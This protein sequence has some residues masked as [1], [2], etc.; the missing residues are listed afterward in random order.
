MALYQ[1][2]PDRKLRAKA[3]AKEYGIGGHSHD[4]L[5]GSRGFV[6]HDW[7][8]LEFDHYPDHQKIT[9]KWAQVEKYIDLMIQSDRYLTDKEKEQRTARQEAECQLPMLDGT[10]AAEYTALKKQYPNTLVGFELNGNYLFYDKDAVAVER[11]L[12][13]NLLSQENVLGKV[14]VTGFPSEQW[15]AESKK[16]WAAGNNVYLAGLNENGS[17][18]QTKYLR[19]ADYLPIGSIIKLDGRDFRVEHVNFT[20]K[21]VSL[22]D[23]E[24]TKNRLPIFRNEHLPHIRELYEEQQDAAIELVPEKE[25]SYKVGDEV[26]VD[27]PTRTIEGT[28]GYIGDTDV[29]I[30][31][32]AHGQSWDNEVINKR[33]F[34]D[35]LR[36]V[37]AQL[38]D[39]ELDELPISAVMDGKV[40]TFPDATAL[41]EAL[42]A[43]P[44]PEPAGNFRITDDHLGEGGAKQKY[45]RN[46]EAIRTLFKLEQEHR[47]ATAEEQQVLSQYVGWGGLSDAFDPSKDNWAKE[48][49]ELKNLLSEDEYT[50]ARSSTLNAH[51]TS[52]VVIRSIYEAVEKMGFKS[53]NI[54][55]PSMGVGNFFGMLPD[56]MADS[57]LYGVELDSI[58]GRIAKKLYPQ[59]DITVA[60]FETTDRRD[61][62]DLAIGNVP[63]G[64]YK[65]NDKAYNKLGFNIHNYFFA[66]AIDQVRPGGVIAFVTSRYT[67]DSKD[68]TARKHMAE[69]A[70]LLG[71]IRLPNN[72]FKANAGTEV[73]SDIIFLQKRDRP[74]DHEPDWV[75]LGKTEDGFAINQYF[76]DHPEMVLGELTTESTP[77]GHDLTV[78]PIEGAVLADQLAEA[79][80]HIEGQYVEV[81][82]E[83]PDVADAEVE[84]K[85]LPADPDVKN[86]SYAVVDGEVYY[87][88][89]S[90]MTQVEL[91][92]NAKARVTG[93]VELRQIVNQ[94]IQEQL[95]DYPDEDIKATQAKLNTAYD[96]FTAK[97]GL[98]NDRKNG[99]L[100]EDDSSY[101]LLCSLENLDEN[102]QLK[103]KADMFTKRTIRPEHTITSVD[104]PSEALAV[105]IGEHGRVDLPYMAELLGS[106]GDYERITTELQG[107]IFKDPSADA[108][109]PEAGWQ[110]ADEYLSG[111]VRN[112]LRMAQLAAESHPE[113]KINVEAL[114]KAQPKDLEASEIDIRLGATWLNPAIVQQFMMETFQPPY[115]IRYNNLIQVRYSPFT[116]EW[117]IGNKSAAGMYDIMSTETYGTHRANAYKILED[118]LNLRDCR[119]YDTIEEDGK[120]RRVLNQKETMLA[121]QKQ[122]AIKDTFAGW[123]WQDP[124]RRNLLVKQYNELF[125]S[126]RPREY[127]GSHIHFVGMNPEINLREHQ[128]N[129]VAHVLYGGNTLLA[130]EVGAGKS[131]EMAAS[132]ME[133]KRL[134]LC[135]KSLF[136]VPNHLT[137]QWA[138]EFLRLYPNAKLLVTSKKDFEPANR[139][140]FCARIAT[141]DYD[142]VIIGHSQFEKIPL[143]AERQARII[144]DQIEEIEKAIAEAKEQSG[145][146]FTV[147]QM[148][149]TRK[150]LEVKLKK[151]QSTDRKDDVVTFEQL[152]VDR[153]FVDESQN[154]KNRAKRCA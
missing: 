49:A 103:S 106:P 146:H 79:V 142:A 127:D 48:Y 147:K 13:T 132:A 152:G 67:M 35:G 37:E 56:T 31:T 95:D 77:Y 151:L 148:E 1:T 114:T 115:R 46:I 80:Q 121:Q 124:Q 75:Q 134:G 72:A 120:E 11:I 21:S 63:F 82:V 70:D 19:E 128:R 97:Y 105:S 32:S 15:A 10:V 126:T 140:R 78:A 28:V 47:G 68:S 102:K 87:R 59:A 81:E 60:G 69:C 116:S 9:L 113:F 22:Q 44:A 17:H 154:Y 27:L 54:L 29:R 41:D 73:V 58:T 101:Y 5:D 14:K 76:V 92:D 144:E 65:V 71:A 129:A 7:K 93:M 141:G 3:L 6:N 50:A 138:S 64:Q 123:V 135:Q 104:T 130:H 90:I 111:N 139:K 39:E 153:L 133:S 4:F 12:R 100:F 38:S 89:N 125:N 74:I 26:V 107:V 88:E 99:R 61:F 62:Y 20:F 149:K 94:L 91:S 122:Q 112:K 117:R 52:P 57:R 119:I 150:T 55:E 45:A 25:V 66:K 53:G 83:T 23:M 118:T 85:T 43:E 145:E 86:F 8:G 108:D 40:Q 98:L 96:A 34:E 137:E 109:E 110:T 30:D 2:Q 143:S 51:Y 42:N 36:Q 136:V 131:F 16:L 18:H 33:Q 24:L 84:R